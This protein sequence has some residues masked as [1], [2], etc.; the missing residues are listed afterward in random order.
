MHSSPV[1]DILGDLYR[2]DKEKIVCHICPT[3]HNLVSAFGST[4]FVANFR[5]PATMIHTKAYFM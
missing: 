3:A 1:V 5:S 4:K 2:V